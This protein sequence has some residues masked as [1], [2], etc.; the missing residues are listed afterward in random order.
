MTL[1][2]KRRGKSGLRKVRRRGTVA[3]KCSRASLPHA[4]QRH[5]HCEGGEAVGL[6]CVSSR[7]AAPD[8]PRRS[9]LRPRQ[10]AILERMAVTLAAQST[11]AYLVNPF[12]I[13]P[14]H[15]TDGGTGAGRDQGAARTPATARIAARSKGKVSDKGTVHC[16]QPFRKL[17]GARPRESGCCLPAGAGKIRGPVTDEVLYVPLRPRA[18]NAHSR[19]SHPVV[20]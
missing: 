20:G 15:C 3:S 16:R 12:L 18:E 10:S 1:R 14:V 4:S 9:H 13:F 7:C 8:S 17:L 11:A 5:L 19:S 2:R 6:R